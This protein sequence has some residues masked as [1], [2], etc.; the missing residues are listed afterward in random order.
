MVR[1]TKLPFSGNISKKKLPVV[2]DE[3]NP[4]HHRGSQKFVYNP[5]ISDAQRKQGLR[6]PAFTMSNNFGNAIPNHPNQGRTPPPPYNPIFTA[7]TMF[8]TNNRISRSENSAGQPP[9]PSTYSSNVSDIVIRNGGSSQDV[10]MQDANLIAFGGTTKSLIPHPMKST[11]QNLAVIPTPDINPYGGASTEMTAFSNPNIRENDKKQL[12]LQDEEGEYYH[13]SLG[14]RKR[15]DETTVSQKRQKTTRYTLGL[16]PTSSRPV[17]GKRK[18]DVVVDTATKRQKTTHTRVTTS[19]LGKRKDDTI[20]NNPVT[21]RQKTTHTR[22]TTS[23]LGKRKDGTVLNNPV[24]KR[25]KTSTYSTVQII[26]KRKGN[27]KTGGH[28]KRRSV[29]PD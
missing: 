13:T 20:L 12:T 27:M 11:S 19:A 14:K 10:T 15:E 8:P 29:I 2:Y 6:A 28:F 5:F 18:H 17:T 16:E 9:P 24:T 3:H 25:Q 22:V 1:K 7:E 21:K 4:H 23:V 26:G